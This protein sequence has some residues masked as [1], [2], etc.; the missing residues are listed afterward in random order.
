MGGGDL[1]P[2]FGT[3]QAVIG[4]RCQLRCYLHSL[5]SGSEDADANMVLIRLLPMSVLLL[6]GLCS[7]AEARDSDLSYVTCG[8]LV[9]LLNTRHNVRLHSHDV[10]YGSGK[11]GSGKL[12]SAAGPGRLCLLPYHH[13]DVSMRL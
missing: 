4:C 1:L 7:D 5:L 13:G 3:C 12:G 9:K 11:L 2:C 8:S 10:K 6:L